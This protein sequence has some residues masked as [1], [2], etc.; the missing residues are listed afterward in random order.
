MAE[1]FAQVVMVLEK[2][3]AAVELCLEPAEIGTLIFSKHFD[4]E[5]D[6]L[7]EIHDPNN[8]EGQTK[9]FLHYSVTI[10]NIID[11]KLLGD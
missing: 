9:A 5:D 7:R 1:F 3:R 6:V 11:K 8:K 10:N 4:H 2:Q